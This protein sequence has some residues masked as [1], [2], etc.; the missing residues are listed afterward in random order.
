V[1]T[2]PQPPPGRQFCLLCA[3]D[4]KAQALAIAQQRK[5][6]LNRDGANLV[7]L[8]GGA[9]PELGVAETTMVLPV[10]P[11]A[12]QPGQMMVVPGMACWVHLLAIKVVD[13][14]LALGTGM[15]GAVLLGQ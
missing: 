6:D 10:P 15:G 3:A 7:A 5:I 12:G 14:Q 13:S 2:G 1:L 8:M 9:L 11:A 4:W